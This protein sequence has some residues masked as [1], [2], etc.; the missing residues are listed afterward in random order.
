M[1]AETF[2]FTSRIDRSAT[3][4][5]KWDARPSTT[6]SAGYT[7]LSIADM[8]VH[9]APCIEHAICKAAHHGIYGYTDSDDIYRDAVVGWMRTRHQWDVQPSWIATTPGVIVA[10][11]LAIRAFTLPGDKVIVQPPVY[12]PF[13]G[14]VLQSG[15]TPTENPLVL[16]ADGHYHMDLTDLEQKASDPH[17]KL[18]LLCSPHNPVGRVWG[19]EELEDVAAICLEHGVVV[20]SDEIH[21][22]II[23]G[24]GSP[25]I[26]MGTLAEKYA[27]NC[28]ICTAPS[29]TFNLAGLANSNIII[30][31]DALRNTFVEEAKRTVPYGIPYFSRAAT[32]AAYTQGAP[33]LVALLDLIRTNYE[34]LTRTLGEHFP[35]VVRIPLEGTY[36]AWSDW[37][38]LGMDSRELEHFMVEE[39]GLVL[40]Q[41]TIFGTGGSGFTRWNLAAPTTVVEESL[42]RLIR[43]GMRRGLTR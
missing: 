26:S 31:G 43:A 6:S 7:P 2:D 5:T 21:G 40:D 22:D 39:A 3:G 35:Q 23:L 42:E 12:Y 11:K 10:L 16:E 14:S 41:G 19:R 33:W 15:C 9:V 25:F 36:L 13:L 20:V 28:I 34:L 17:A 24:G 8:E 1:P 38:A 18:L 4:S 32:I 37:R 30:P 27:A 29:K